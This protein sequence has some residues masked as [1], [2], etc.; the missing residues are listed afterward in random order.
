MVSLLHLPLL[1]SGLWWAQN[2]SSPC[3]TARLKISVGPALALSKV[4]QVLASGMGG[5][6]AAHLC[7]QPG[8]LLLYQLSSPP[9]SHKP[10]L[11]PLISC[12]ESVAP[13]H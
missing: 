9:C 3:C 6:R 2:P 8:K 11:A 12:P 13:P 1:G 5:L 4:A 10:D 7:T